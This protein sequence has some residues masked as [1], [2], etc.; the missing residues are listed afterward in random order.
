MEAFRE[1]VRGWLGKAFLVLL[2]V[3]FAIVGVESYFSGGGKKVAAKVNG[4][5]I[6]QVE[7]DRQVERQRQQLLA[8][9]GPN[10]DPA[11][12]DLK[13]IRK[14]VLDGLVNQELLAQQSGKSGYLISDA[15]ITKQIQ[16]VPAFQENGK[17]SRSRYEQVLRQNGEDPANFYVL[18]KQR[19]AYS[20]MLEGIAQSGI[21]TTP[22]LERLSELS[23]QKRDI[24]YATIPAARYLSEISVSDADVKQYYDAHPDRF[25]TPETVTLDY[26]TLSRD[27]F[28]AQAQ[29]SEEDLQARYED[30]VRENAAN[31]QRD[32]QHILIAVNDK[33]SDADALKKIQ[34]IEKRARAGEDFG[35][36]AKEFSQ[37]PGSVANGGDLGFA[38]RGTFDPQFDKALFSLKVG[39]ISGPV[40]SQYGYHLIKLNKVKTPDTPSFAA[41]KPELEKEAKTA[42]ADELFSETADKLDAAV[43]ESSD[44]KEPAEKFGRPIQVTQP[45][46]RQGGSGIAAERKVVEAAFSDEQLNEGKSSESLHL[47]DGSVVWIHVKNHQPAA[48]KPFAEV[49]TEARNQLSLEKA[50]EKAKAVAADVAKAIN[51]GASLAAAGDRLE[52][53]DVAGVTRQSEAVAPS[54]LQTAYRLPHPAAGKLTA[55]SLENG[56][57]FVVVA[58]SGVTPGEPGDKAYLDQMR[59]VLSES[60]SRQELQDY[61][62]FLRDSGKVV[63]NDGK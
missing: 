38:S 3:P 8:Q 13:R 41:L 7:L 37:D 43:Y 44:L 36:L 22:E 24:H 16:E 15:T 11:L 27:D 49:S 34:E 29:P 42:K 20:L 59:N 45:F 10:A 1:M 5:D 47:P 28:L 46:T 58:V 62:R 14:N 2:V 6:L 50:R 40:R 31:E 12:L 9:M 17:F 26:I 39:E 54:I 33:T 4:T 53:H 25:T 63:I 21:V 56:P 19:L 32:A 30:K 35:K 61:V 18:A 48:L 23:K 60:R 51:G 57:S 52:W 55:D